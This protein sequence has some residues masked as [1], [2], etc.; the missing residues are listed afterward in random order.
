MNYLILTYATNRKETEQMETALVNLLANRASVA[1]A[2]TNC[3]DPIMQE[4]LLQ[5]LLQLEANILKLKHGTEN[6]DA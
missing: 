4:V 3:L 2:L 1:N 6:N 5:T